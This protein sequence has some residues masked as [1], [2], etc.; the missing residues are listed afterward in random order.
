[1]TVKCFNLSNAEQ[2]G[3]LKLVTVKNKKA[4]QATYVKTNIVKSSN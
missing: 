4:I 1:M 2:K 3:L